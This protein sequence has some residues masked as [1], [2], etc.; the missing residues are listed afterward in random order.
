ML[1]E[2]ALLGDLLKIFPRVLDRFATRVEFGLVLALL[3][4]AAFVGD[5]E[6]A[7]HAWQHQSLSDQCRDDDAEGDE[8][9]QVALRKRR[10]ARDGERDRQR[11]CERDDATHAGKRQHEG[12]D[13]KSTRL[14]SSH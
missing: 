3:F 2:L 4:G 9:D 10:A 6:P 12:P 7:D 14:N 1:V 13:R 11:R 5:A 8:Q